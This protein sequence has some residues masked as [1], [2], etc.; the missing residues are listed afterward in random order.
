MLSVDGSTHQEQAQDVWNCGKKGAANTKRIGRPL[1]AKVDCLLDLETAWLICA[2]IQGCTHFETSKL[3]MLLDKSPK[4]RKM[5]A[6]N[7]VERNL[8]LDCLAQT[9]RFL[10]FLA[11]WPPLV[12]RI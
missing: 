10:N 11:S 12:S 4:N 9:K 2:E 8:L 3:C 5:L 1:S 7:V 6:I